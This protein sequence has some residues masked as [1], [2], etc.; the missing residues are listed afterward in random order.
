MMSFLNAHPRAR[1]VL[2]AFVLG[3][4]LAGPVPGCAT[5]ASVIAVLPSIIKLV[6]H[7]T[8]ALDMISDQVAAYEQL[9][10]HVAEEVQSAIDDA[11]V[12]FEAVKEAAK[13]ADSFNDGKLVEAMASARK[14]YEAV[15]ALCAKYGV[16]VESTE[17]PALG[18]KTSGADAGSVLVV[19]S[20]DRMLADAK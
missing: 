18:L 16:T 7:A 9:S 1:A 5:L 12:A 3:F 2:F 4:S 11:R 17:G 8:I 14:A 19:P 15:H 10:P 6:D 20:F 13:G